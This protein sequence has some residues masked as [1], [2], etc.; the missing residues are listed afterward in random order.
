[1]AKFNGANDIAPNTGKITNTLVNS[2]Q[3][4]FA[5]KFEF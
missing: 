3:I 1:M 5:V 4:Q 2:R